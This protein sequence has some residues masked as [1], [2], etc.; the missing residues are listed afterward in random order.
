MRGVITCSL[1]AITVA[2]VVIGLG[3]GPIDA[4]QKNVLVAKKVAAAPPLDGTLDGAWKSAAGLTVK[5]MGGKNHP[6]GSTEITTRAVYTEDTVYFH[7]Q[8]K[9]ATESLRR[10]PWVKQ[11]DGSWQ[12]LRDP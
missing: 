4:Q 2:A 11:A 5:A 3:A 9:D 6:G 10:S 7:V 8:Y 1:A 12:K